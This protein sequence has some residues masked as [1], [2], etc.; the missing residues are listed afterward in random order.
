MKS[1]GTAQVQYP[2]AVDW[3]GCFQAL[4]PFQLKNNGKSCRT[5]NDVV[6]ANLVLDILPCREDVIDESRDI[7]DALDRFW[8]HEDMGVGQEEAPNVESTMKFEHDNRS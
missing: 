6:N 2:L 4:Y 3:V 5:V 1:L 8:K 7:V